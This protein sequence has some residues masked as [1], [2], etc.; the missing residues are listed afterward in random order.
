MDTVEKFFCPFSQL[1]AEDKA[2]LKKYL[3]NHFAIIAQ[4][5]R[6]FL[7][8]FLKCRTRFSHL[9]NLWAR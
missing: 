9:Q 8:S 1:P 7:L 2:F 6:P 4:N 3:S 5:V